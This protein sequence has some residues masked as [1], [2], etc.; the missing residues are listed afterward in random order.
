MKKKGHFRLKRFILIIIILFL[1]GLTIGVLGYKYFFDMTW[2]D[3]LFNATI[4]MSTLGIAPNEKT[5]GEKIFTGFY[6][7][8]SGVFFISLVSA[9]IQ[10][11]F[12]IYVEE[13]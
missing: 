3:A 2:T 11:V 9:V 10:Y 7:I 5:A 13:E 12:N 8:L 6:A 4:S 1:L